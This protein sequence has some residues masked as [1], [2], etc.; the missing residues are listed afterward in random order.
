MEK[1]CRILFLLGTISTLASPV[2]AAAEPLLGFNAT[3]ETAQRDLE[4]AFDDA[5]SAE[6]LGAWMQHLSAQPHHV[7]SAYG[8]ENAEYLAQLFKSWGYDTKLERYDILLPVPEH[9]QLQLLEPREFTASL[10]ERALVED[11]STSVRDELL[12]PYNAYSVD[13]D[14]TAELVFAN[15]GTPED[16]EMLARFGIDVAGKIVIVK[17]GRTFRG[18]KPKVAAE[19]GAIEDVGYPAT[20]GKGH[21]R[22]GN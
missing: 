11:P 10:E 18:I 20:V 13:G 5:L 3:Q 16:Y 4:A 7:G 21:H 12:P 9:R 2:N 1:F 8:K 19:N 22:V 6:D 17:Y 14:V 15:Y